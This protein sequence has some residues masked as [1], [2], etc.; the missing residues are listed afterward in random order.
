LS[1]DTFQGGFKFSGQ[2][3]QTHP[4]EPQFALMMVGAFG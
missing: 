3:A 4:P 2:A 1:P